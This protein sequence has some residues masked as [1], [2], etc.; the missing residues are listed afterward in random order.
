M[1]R[2]IVTPI[3]RGAAR[4]ADFFNF[5]FYAGRS[6]AESSGHQVPN[7]GNTGEA[8]FRRATFAAILRPNLRK[9]FGKNFGK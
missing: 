5:A 3:E 7:S 6:K 9:R 8:E 4:T 2:A 1:I